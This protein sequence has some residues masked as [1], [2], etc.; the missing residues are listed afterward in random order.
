VER[1][2][3]RRTIEGLGFFLLGRE[4]RALSRFLE[5]LVDAERVVFA[6]RYMHALTLILDIIFG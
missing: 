4:Q 3:S 6:L 5:G 2:A 1:W